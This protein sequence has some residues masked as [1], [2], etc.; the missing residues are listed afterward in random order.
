[1]ISTSN[2]YKTAIDAPSRRV[3]PNA[4]IDLTDPDLDVTSVSGDLASTYSFTAQIA[5]KDMTFSG[6]VY[7]TLETSRWILDGSQSI[8]PDTPSTRDGE[9][10]VI[11]DTL[12]GSDGTLNK[13]LTV[14]FNDVEL[15]QAVTVSATGVPA[16]GRPTQLTLGVYSNSVLMHT[17]TATLDGSSLVFEGFTVTQPDKIVLT[18]DKW[19]LPGRRFR[20]V[21]FLPGHIETWGAD[22]IY[23]F[24]VIRKCDISNLTLPF[25]SAT[26]EIDNTNK[27]FDPMNK[28]GMFLTLTARQPVTMSMGVEIA[29]SFEYV[30]SGIYYL[31]D[32]GWKTQNSGMTMQF[33]MVD[34]VG[35]LANRKYVLGTMPSTL[36]G[37]ISDIVSQ[38]GTTFT[39][40]YIID[41]SLGTT[42]LSCSADD[43]EDI[44]CGD[45]LRYLCQAVGAFPMSDPATGYLHIT[46]INNAVRRQITLRSQNAVPGS[47]ANQDIAFLAFKVNGTDYNIPGTEEIG[48]QTVSIENPFITTLIGAD[49]ASQAILPQ[50]GG[51]A[52]SVNWRGDMSV[53][54][55]DIEI[56]EIYPDNL[57]A[58]RVV[59]QRLTLANGVMTNVPI[60]LLQA[61]GMNLYTDYIIITESGTYTMP[62][63]VTDITIVL[64]GG[65]DGGYGGPS[66]AVIGDAYGA[67]GRYGGLGGK[68]YTNAITINDG[69]SVDVV[70]GRGGNGGAGGHFPQGYEP[71]SVANG[72]PGEAG[73]DTTADF[74][75]VYSSASGVRMDHGYVDLLTNKVYGVPG[76]EGLPKQDPPRAGSDATPNTGNGGNGGQG[77]RD[78]IVGD[79]DDDGYP[80]HVIEMPLNGAVGGRGADGVCIIFYTR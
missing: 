13:M 31:N 2:D 74:G 72:H 66:G 55:G 59:E 9:Q 34:I 11:G 64:I 76:S 53:D 68:V 78:G 28:D 45:L 62:A 30:Q 73:G 71:S 16:D 49:L 51:N 63:G 22:R 79:Y 48:G 10:G 7:A 40:H 24:D 54:P 29:D 58:A 23:K 19:S 37:W 15:L 80:D 56:V 77:G 36:E 32:K 43:V 65:G 57:T 60:K 25:A 33:D 50:Y 46:K 70:I 75:I 26:L 6:A 1:L 44:S 69:Q 3:V 20:F 4:V 38:L 47:S 27:R 12:S 41:D 8:M 17:E 21:E 61:D 14:E 18:V 39:G 5:D 35:L 67:T 42:A 52:L